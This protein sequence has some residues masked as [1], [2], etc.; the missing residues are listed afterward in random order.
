MRLLVSTTA[1][2]RLVRG[3]MYGRPPRNASR[4]QSPAYS[5]FEQRTTFP[6]SLEGRSPSYRSL[7]SRS[8]RLRC[9]RAASRRLF[10]A[11]NLLLHGSIASSHRSTLSHLHQCAHSNPALAPP[12][13]T[14][15]RAGDD[16]PVK[17]RV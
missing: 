17:R 2:F 1:S 5:P 3:R 15:T 13:P 14:E 9:F 4:T 10:S 7:R 16:G 12:T 8:S 11:P 6:F